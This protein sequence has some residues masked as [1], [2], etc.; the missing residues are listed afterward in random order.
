MANL[1]DR[2]IRYL[3]P[4]T[5]LKREQARSMLTVTENVNKAMASGYGNY[6]ASRKKNALKGWEDG[7]G[8]A[9][10]DIQDNLQTLRTRSRDLFMGVPLANGA[11]KTYR[12]NVIGSGLTP[13][14]TIDAEA[15]G[16][17]EEQAG[18]IERQISTEFNLWADSVNCDAERIDNFYGLQQLVILNW[19]M[20]GDVFATLPMK[21]RPGCPYETC[22]QLIEADRVSTPGYEL[23]MELDQKIVGGV[24]VDESGEVV[25]YHVSKYH[26]LS[27]RAEEQTWTRVEAFGSQTGRRNILHVMTRERIGQRRGVPIMAPVIEAVKQIGR[28]TDAEIMAAVVSG[29]MTVFIQTEQERQEVPL[30]EILDEAEE[31]TVNTEDKRSVRLGPGSIIDL[32]P[33]E[34]ANAVT[35]GR[36]NTNFDGFVAAIAKQIG[37]SLELPYE[38][39]M[40]QFTASY[41]ASRAALL[42]AW[43]SFKAWREWEIEKFCQ[44][45]YEE[46]LTE[47]VAKG[48]VK[49]PGFFNDPTIRKAYCYAEWYGPTQGQLD[50]VKEI[51][52][53]QLRV[54]NGF[55]SRAKEAMELTGTDFL[56]NMKSARQEN[57]LMKEV[58][59][60]E[61]QTDGNGDDER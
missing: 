24:E 39:L 57:E 14:P 4:E 15:A 13:K 10:E 38:L 46:W 53:A 21:R 31:L 7:G 54:I 6:G 12:T 33:G 30:G 28:Y 8:S 26:P 35:P 22:I 44:P 60:V 19:M 51:T 3:S 40:K 27:I 58:F 2:L 52:A 5:A 17:S 23:G 49:A 50:P 9:L 42:E 16:I 11:I 34:K 47:A 32:A 48:R 41:S 36:P 20:S 18:E 1:L 29:Y 61:S 55:S 37:A 45:V 56:D 59:Q 25:A 43:K